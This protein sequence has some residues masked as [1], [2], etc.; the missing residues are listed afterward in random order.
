MLA[1]IVSLTHGLVAQSVTA[2]LVRASKRSL[3]VVGSN[4]PQANVL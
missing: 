1:R 4:P 3:M 2:Q